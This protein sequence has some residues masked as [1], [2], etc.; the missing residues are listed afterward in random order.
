MSF[1][2][3]F[4]DQ[5]DLDADPVLRGRLIIL[6]RKDIHVAWVSN[7]ALELTIPNLPDKIDGGKILRDGTGNPTGMSN[8]PPGFQVTLRPWHRHI[9]GSGYPVRP[10]SSLE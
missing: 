9:P 7:K 3:E 5:A 8:L 6:F 10:C 1:T 4:S 2:H